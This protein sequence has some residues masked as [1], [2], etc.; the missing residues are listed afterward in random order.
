MSF[1]KLNTILRFGYAIYYRTQDIVVSRAKMQFLRT[2][3]S[4]FWDLTV[5]FWG[6]KK[7]LCRKGKRLYN[8]WD[9]VICDT[10][11]RR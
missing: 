6:H 11:F 10:Y 9:Y 1:F 5:L 4:V 8:I 7:A 2:I 3:S